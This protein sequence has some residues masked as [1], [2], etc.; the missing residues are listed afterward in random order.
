MIKLNQIATCAGARGE[1][2]WPGPTPWPRP[3]S[4][5]ASA[6]AR[7]PQ[8]EDDPA[9]RR[10]PLIKE[11]GSV[12]NGGMIQHM[13]YPD[14]FMSQQETFISNVVSMA[15]D[16]K[17]KA[18]IVNQAIPGTAEAF[19][20]VHSKRPD[21]YCLAG[22]AHEDPLVIAGAADFVASNDFVS[23][24]YTIIWAAKQMGAKTFVHISF[25]RHMSYESMG[26]RRSIMEAACKDLGL[27][28]AFETAP[29]PTIRRGRGRRPAVHPREGSG[30]AQEVR[31]Q[32]REGRLL[33]H[34]R[35]PHRAPA[36]AADGLQ[37]R[38]VRGSRPAQ[39]R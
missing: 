30:L 24:G 18:I 39:A 22:E 20:R 28:F 4:T 16:P 31:P 29:D 19:K 15:D 32:R 34:Q 36:E 7:C 2:S 17:M 3:S 25:P 10:G 37:E 27:K 9:R 35:R 5:S 12:K 21:I 13:T 14:D 8:S 11:Y 38:R 26:R 23:R 1:C 6:P 33:L